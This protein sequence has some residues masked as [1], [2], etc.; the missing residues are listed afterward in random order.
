MSSGAGC[1][2]LRSGATPANAGRFNNDVERGEWL[3]LLS[4]HAGWHM[5]DGR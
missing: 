1:C 5:R 4:D 2:E 3:V